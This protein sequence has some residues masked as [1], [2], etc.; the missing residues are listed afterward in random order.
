MAK[1]RDT[2]TYNLKDGRKVVYKGIS[3]DPE[4]REQ[5][6][7]KSGKKITGIEIT[8]RKMT[9]EGAKNK[10][11]NDLETYRKN[12]GGKNPKFNKDSDG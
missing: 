10:E 6:H 9:R 5:E 11:A 12:H 2:V 4:K 1:K 7:R 3:N 8:S